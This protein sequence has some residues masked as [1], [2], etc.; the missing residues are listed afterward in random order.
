MIKHAAIATALLVL[1]AGSADAQGRGNG[2]KNKNGKIPP[3]HMPPAGQ[4]RVWYDGVPPGHQ[5]APT[6][7]AEAERI[8]ARDG[9][10]RVIYSDGRD[11]RPSL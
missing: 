10:A 7:C 8:A 5:P 1:A 4:C 3:G 6:N 2:N 9:G 11:S